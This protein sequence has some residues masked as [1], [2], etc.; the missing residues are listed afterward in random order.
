MGPSGGERWEPLAYIDI[1]A[2]DS[3]KST[4]GIYH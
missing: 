2:I 4:H 1:I 3:V